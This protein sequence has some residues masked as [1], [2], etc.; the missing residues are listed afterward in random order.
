MECLK[1]MF[2]L[3]AQ[4][5]YV[6]CHQSFK[7]GTLDKCQQLVIKPNLKYGHNVIFC[8]SVIALNNGHE[9]VFAKHYNFTL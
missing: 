3:A 9:S 4:N 5:Y 7:V 6:I 1:Y 2:N 8:S